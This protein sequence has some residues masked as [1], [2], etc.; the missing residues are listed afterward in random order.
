MSRYSGKRS[1]VP[2]STPSL[3][4]RRMARLRVEDDVREHEPLSLDH[5]PDPAGERHGEDRT[6]VHEGVELAVLAARVDRGRQVCQQPFVEL[7]TC[8]GSVQDSWIDTTDD[9]PKA[10][11]D[12]LSGQLG[13][14]SA[15]DRKQ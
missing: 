10:G 5:G 11:V 14:V 9:R 3:C 7:T 15:P 6:R 4:R 13:R 8:E 2:R 12:E 1:S